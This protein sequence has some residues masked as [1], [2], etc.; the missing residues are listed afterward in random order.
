[1][2]LFSL[3]SIPSPWLLSLA[4]F[5]RSPSMLLHRLTV[6]FFL[7]LNSILVSRYLKICTSFVLYWQVVFSILIFQIQVLWN[8][9]LTFLV[10]IIVIVVEK[11]DHVTE[12]LEKWLFKETVK[13]LHFHQ[14]CIRVQA[15]LLFVNPC[16]WFVYF[17]H[18]NMCMA[19]SLWPQFIFSKSPIKFDK[20][21][22]D[23]RWY[24]K[25]SI[26][27]FCL[28][29]LV[30][31][32]F[33]IVFSLHFSFPFPLY[34]PFRVLFQIHALWFINCYCIHIFTYI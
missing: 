13:Q 30:F 33:E 32:V 25:T 24:Y 12:W 19:I 34:K 28:F 31:F 22:C 18:L 10:S 11:L 5:F 7:F 23:I 27:A 17:R 2:D 6:H 20:Y 15:P 3:Y 26:H 14:Q 1:M 29:H 4:E 8:F 16:V 21:S 9:W